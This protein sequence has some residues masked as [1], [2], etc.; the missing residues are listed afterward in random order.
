MSEQTF[1]GKGGVTFLCNGYGTGPTIGCC[2]DLSKFVAALGCGTI[3]QCVSK[4]GVGQSIVPQHAVIGRESPHDGWICHMPHT[5]LGCD[6]NSVLCSVNWNVPSLCKCR[7]VPYFA[8]R[9]QDCLSWLSFG[10][11]SFKF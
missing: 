2:K 10:H 7:C 4:H 1:K 6:V 3:K 9:G 8:L 11:A 5:S